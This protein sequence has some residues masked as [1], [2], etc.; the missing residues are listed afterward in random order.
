L[1]TVILNVLFILAAVI[2]YAVNNK[3][4]VQYGLWEGLAF[5]VVNMIITAVKSGQIAQLKVQVK[6][7]TARICKQN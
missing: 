4:F 5:L 6:T 7:L 2:E 3:M 1:K